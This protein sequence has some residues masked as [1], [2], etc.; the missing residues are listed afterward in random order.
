MWS[1]K[2]SGHTLVSNN[3]DEDRLNMD[4]RL[5]S[6]PL[7]GGTSFLE[8]SSFI[9]TTLRYKKRYYLY[10][11][12]KTCRS[13]IRLSMEPVDYTG[14]VTSK[15][16]LKPQ[17]RRFAGFLDGLEVQKDVRI[18]DFGCGSGALLSELKKLG[19]T[20]IQGYEPF[21]QKYSKTLKAGNFSLVYLVHVF[22][23]IADLEAFFRDLDKVTKGRSTIIVVCPSSTRIPNLDPTCPFQQYTVHAPFHTVIPSDHQT[24]EVFARN[25]YRLRYSLPYDVQRSGILNNGRVAALLNQ[26]LGG[27]KERLLRAN[28]LDAIALV[29]RKPLPSFNCM[30]LHRQDA[31]VTTYVFEKA[32]SS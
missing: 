10:A 6:C 25:G 20:K 4:V 22:E 21:N 30:F 28:L 1:K 11:R 16:I 23:H 9:G 24:T 12:C 8:H 27:I 31:F 18:L 14:Y 17:V 13:I 3:A 32:D 29:I 26:A 2:L 5:D 15:S 7:C 19:Y